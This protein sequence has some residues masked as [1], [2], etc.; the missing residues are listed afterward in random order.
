MRIILLVGLLLLAWPHVVLAH[1]SWPDNPYN[2]LHPPAALAAGNHAP[3]AVERNI[4]LHGQR[5]PAIDVGTGDGQAQIIAAAGALAGLSGGT[6]FRVAIAPVEIPPGLPASLTPN[7]NAYRI[8]LVSA[9]GT[10]SVAIIKPVQVV[11]K[12]AHK[13]LSI[14]VYSGGR[15][16]RVCAADVNSTAADVVICRSP[17][18]GTFLLT[19]APFSTNAPQT[20]FTWLNPYIPMLSSLCVIVL[21]AVLGILA[22]RPDPGK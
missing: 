9:P 15:W 13:P 3:G 12:W 22:L 21:A 18:I 7:G 6:A 19:T 17:V 20:P 16:R 4:P 1:G 2:Y 14:E 11:L 5:S 10:G 8:R